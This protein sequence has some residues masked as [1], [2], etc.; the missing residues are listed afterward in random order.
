M[1]RQEE[2]PI[3]R[4]LLQY[5]IAYI[6]SQYDIENASLRIPYSAQMPLDFFKEIC[7]GDNQRMAIITLFALLSTKRRK[8]QDVYAWSTS[9]RPLLRKLKRYVGQDKVDGKMTSTIYYQPFI[10]QLT[11]RELSTPNSGGFLLDSDTKAAA[12]SETED[13]G[14]DGEETDKR[15]DEAALPFNITA[16]EEFCSRNTAQFSRTFNMDIRTS[17]YPRK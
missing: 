2:A 17:N 12:E 15:E 6:D 14:E 11:S 7:T 1:P 9:F 5:R 16:F 10:D 13:E 8:D 3:F 4:R